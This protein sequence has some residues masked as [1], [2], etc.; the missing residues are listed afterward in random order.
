MCRSTARISE[1]WLFQ[2]PGEASGG[3][4]RHWGHAALELCRVRRGSARIP[5]WGNP[6]RVSTGKAP[7]KVSREPDCTT[8]R[9]SPSSLN[10]EKT[11]KVVGVAGARGSARV[12]TSKAPGK[13]SREPDSAITRLSSF[14]LNTE[15]I[16]KVVGVAGARGTARVSTSKAPGKVSREP[17]SAIT[18]LS[19]FLLNT[20]KN[21]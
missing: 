5:L 15:K 21:K 17:D 8:T 7:G 6:G 10:T 20:E 13:V 1:T 14:L 19:S 16:S 18:R 4:L 12:S 9:L 2:A 3:R 11:S